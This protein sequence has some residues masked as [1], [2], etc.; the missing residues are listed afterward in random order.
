MFEFYK[1]FNPVARTCNVVGASFS[2]RLDSECIVWTT[3][4]VVRRLRAPFHTVLPFVLP[5]ILH[6]PAA[7]SFLLHTWLRG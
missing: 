6:K 4:N 1:Y 5:A 2:V 3:P 7:F